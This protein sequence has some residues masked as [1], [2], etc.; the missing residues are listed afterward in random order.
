MRTSQKAPQVMGQAGLSNRG[1]ERDT[2]L[3]TRLT[4]QILMSE[5][6]P[7]CDLIEMV[8]EHVSV[9]SVAPAAPK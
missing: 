7:Q 6:G 9:G 8:P 5:L 1:E 2:V 4:S 3:P